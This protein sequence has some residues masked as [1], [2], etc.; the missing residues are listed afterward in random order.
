MTRWIK[1]L[2]PVPAHSLWHIYTNSRTYRSTLSAGR[3]PPRVKE[4][5]D[6]LSLSSKEWGCCGGVIHWLVP[7][8]N[9]VINCSGSHVFGPSPPTCQDW[10][11]LES[12]G[13][14]VSVGSRWS[15]CV[16]VCHFSR[17]I[18]LAHNFS[19]CLLLDHFTSARL[20]PSWS[21]FRIHSFITPPS[22]NSLPLHW[23]LW[24]AVTAACLACK[25][26]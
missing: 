20:S 18:D 1:L 6:R 12:T 23:A 25:V 5:L 10:Q 17:M 11:P 19:V 21:V 2:V 16:N 13:V 3:T 22:L 26:V 14:F 7:H 24:Q 9:G 4:R 15:V 8:L